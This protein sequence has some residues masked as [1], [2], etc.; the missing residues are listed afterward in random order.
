[1]LV[2]QTSI[3][4]G[5]LLEFLP[6]LRYFLEARRKL[7]TLIANRYLAILAH[8]YI[9][10]LAVLTADNIFGITQENVLRISSKNAPSPL[11]RIFL[12]IWIHSDRRPKSCFEALV[13]KI[14]F[15]SIAHFSSR[16]A[17]QNSMQAHVTVAAV[18]DQTLAMGLAK[19]IVS[20]VVTMLQPQVKHIKDLILSS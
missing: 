17:M 9:I 10:V 16:C 6:S 8:S 14:V 19:L 20:H 13:R 5:K 12:Q 11:P 3:K 15:P 7:P 2:T 4:N 1:M 18:L